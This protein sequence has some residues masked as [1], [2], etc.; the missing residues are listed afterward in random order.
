MMTAI[1]DL[2]IDAAPGFGLR[3]IE[4]SILLPAHLPYQR[5]QRIVQL[6]FDVFHRS[7]I[8]L[9]DRLLRCHVPPMPWPSGSLLVVPGGKLTILLGHN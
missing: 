5:S 6:L 2:S 8:D 7:N 3:Q 1:L 9:D 4:F